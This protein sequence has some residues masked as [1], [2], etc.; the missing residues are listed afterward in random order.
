MKFQ[1]FILTLTATSALVTPVHA[2]EPKPVKEAKPNILFIAVDDLRPD[3]GVY[4]SPIVKSPNIDKIA[5]SGLTFE[6]AYCQYALCNPSRSSLLSGRRPETLKIYNLGTHVDTHQ[7]DV[8]TLPKY[9]RQNGYQTIRYGKIF[10]LGHGNHDGIDTWD[11]SLNDNGKPP[12]ARRKDKNEPKPPTPD[13]SDTHPYKAPDVADNELPDGRV[14]DQA[15]A[16]I[17][18]LNT[19]KPFFLAVGFYKPH[20]PFVAPKKYWD[21]YKEEDIKLAENRFHPKDAPL[22]ANNDASELRR[23]KGIPQTGSIPDEQAR[24]LRHGYYASV[25]YMDAQI[26][27]ILDALDKKNL[28]EN[29]IIVLWGDHGYQ[30]GEHNTWTKRTNWELGTRVPLIL[31]VPGQETAGSKSNALVEL[32]DIY[33]TL[34]DLAK[35]PQPPKIEGLS[36]VPLVK[37]P[38]IK[39]KSG[40]FSSL[41]VKDPETSGSS[42]FGRALRTD[43]HRLV[44]WTYE[45][46]Q[47]PKV[48]ELYDLTKD[49]QENTNIANLPENKDLVARLTQQLRQ[50]WKGSLPPK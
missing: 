47:K 50:G 18:A 32:V 17:N 39:W 46:A 4:G 9:L 26:G 38:K 8:V 1:N 48:Y 23:Y 7:P 33:P 34:L 29:T 49:P 45:T 15:V 25:S 44:E 3:L 20:L 43:T 19:D 37:D 40:A 28:R 35:L 2:Q 22:F 5:K 30:L 16:K 13:H 41:E 11:E 31:S 24:K 27:K 10:H 12:K 6:R 14:A 36:F 21:L 42:I